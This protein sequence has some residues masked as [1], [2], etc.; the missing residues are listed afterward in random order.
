MKKIGTLGFL[1]LCLAFLAL[2][3]LA[4]QEPGAE[5]YLVYLIRPTLQSSSLIL[6]DIETD[7][8]KPI[9]Q[10]WEVSAFSLSPGMRLAFSANRDGKNEVYVVDFPY[11]ET[12]T[13]VAAGVS[14]DYFPV[15]WSPDGKL[16]LINSYESNYKYL[17]EKGELL[18]WDERDL[19][20]IYQHQGHVSEFSLR[21]DNQLAFTDFYKFN[22][23][24]PEILLWDGQSVVN[25]SQNPN[26]T[27]R[28]PS[29]N[30][31]GKLA[32]LSERNDEYDILIWNGISKDDTGSP[33]TKSFVNVAPELTTY[34]SRPVWTSSGTI[35]FDGNHERCGS[36]YEW[37][38][39]FAQRITSNALGAGALA[40]L[41]GGQTWSKDGVWAF[42]SHFRFSLGLSVLSSNNDS[43]LLSIEDKIVSPPSWN[44]RGVLLFCTRDSEWKL[45]IWNRVEVLDLV[46]GYSILAKWPNGTEVH[47]NDG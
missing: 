33:D 17:P 34:L 46:H 41:H 7:T 1:I 11:S 15:S 4:L 31:S 2:T 22:N 3:N 27:D 47:C 38:G 21:L 9:M 44:E 10:G 42:V 37:N 45:F 43:I 5:D 12:P 30:K 16:L 26:G 36:L 29:W 24:Q 23:D 25:L 39:E 28:F 32:F 19:F 20:T 13:L 14:S 35:A 40:C 6:Y 18:I 8:H